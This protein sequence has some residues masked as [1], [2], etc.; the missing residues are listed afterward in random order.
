MFLSKLGRETY[1]DE[2]TNP[3]NVEGSVVAVWKAAEGT[4]YTFC[5]DV[6][7]DNGRLNAYRPVDLELINS[8][9]ENE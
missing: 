5:M 3:H 8:I 1:P 6:T 4:I 7:W 2:L 9:V